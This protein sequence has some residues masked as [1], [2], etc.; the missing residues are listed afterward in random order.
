L[1][2]FVFLIQGHMVDVVTKVTL[3]ADV[4]SLSTVVTGLCEGFEGPSAVD[5]HRMPG[6]SAR[7]GVCI[8][9][10]VAAVGGCQWMKENRVCGGAMCVVGDGTE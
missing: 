7:E 1:D 5:V 4:A 3:S 9:A 10:G 2:K 8:A 6:G